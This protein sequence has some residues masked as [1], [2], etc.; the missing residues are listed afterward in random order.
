[1]TG[2]ENLQRLDQKLRTGL[3]SATWLRGRLHV[4]SPA[5]VEDG[6]DQVLTYLEREVAPRARAE[7]TAFYPEVARWLGVDLTERMVSE[8]RSVDTLVARLRD[9][10]RRIA[11]TGSVPPELYSD[12]TALIDLVTAHLRVEGEALQGMVDAGLSDAEAY[13]LYEE[14][15]IAEFEETAHQPVWERLATP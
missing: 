15:E 12:L 2:V 1:M 8:H 5:A 3:G 4:L 6:L 13:R 14:M 9:V 7:E 10:K 11:E